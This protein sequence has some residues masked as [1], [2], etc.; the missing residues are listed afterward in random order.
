MWQSNCAQAR[1]ERNLKVTQDWSKDKPWR[2]WWE[3]LF[4]SCTKWQ[5][6]SGYISKNSPCSF[7]PMGGGWG[8]GE[9]KLTCWATFYFTCQHLFFQ[10]Q[11]LLL[12]HKR[13]YTLQ[14]ISLSVSFFKFSH[15]KCHW[16]WKTLCFFW[17]KI[18]LTD[19]TWPPEA[20]LLELG[21][22]PLFL[23]PV[24]CWLLQI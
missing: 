16:C 14:T 19:E 11:K 3:Q 9:T 13:M 17:T 20:E 23:A 21:T 24:S 6:R 4:D 22:L 18:V 8:R 5:A 15:T 10:G 1:E 7:Q 12:K 2:I